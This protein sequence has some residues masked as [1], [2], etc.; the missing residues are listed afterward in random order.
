MFLILM[1]HKRN[2]KRNIYSWFSSYLATI[3]VFRRSD[4][5]GENQQ[6]GNIHTATKEEKKECTT[7]LAKWNKIKWFTSYNNNKWRWE[8]HQCC[9]ST[10]CRHDKSW[11]DASGMGAVWCDEVDTEHGRDGLAL[12]ASCFRREFRIRCGKCIVCSRCHLGWVGVV[13][14]VLGPTTTILNVLRTPHLLN[15]TRNLWITVNRHMIQT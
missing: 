7:I 3:T 11:G 5:N 15:R 2:K 14:A 6:R 10:K 4:V 9:T 12:S 8:M 13:L 1:N